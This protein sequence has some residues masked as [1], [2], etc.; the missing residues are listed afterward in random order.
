[1]KFNSIN[2]GKMSQ[3]SVAYNSSDECLKSQPT[4]EFKVKDV[5]AFEQTISQK[6]LA[7][8]SNKEVQNNGTMKLE[9]SMSESKE[10]PESLL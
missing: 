6:S 5:L 8:Y 10:E 7:V 3:N 2:N 9:S 1:M 4:Q